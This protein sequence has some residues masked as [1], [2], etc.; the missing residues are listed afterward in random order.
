MCFSRWDVDDEVLPTRLI[1]EP[2]K[3]TSAVGGAQP[4]KD[5]SSIYQKP[6]EDP[7]IKEAEYSDE[8]ELD[9]Y[10]AGVE[11]RDCLQYIALTFKQLFKQKRFMFTLN[12]LQ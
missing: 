11:V 4:K 7:E 5:F 1:G 10:M 3:K 12:I 9:K 6:S 2:P 8:D